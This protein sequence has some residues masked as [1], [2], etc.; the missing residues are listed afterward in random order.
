[1]SYGTPKAPPAASYTI[2]GDTAR[3]AGL[4]A[5]DQRDMSRSW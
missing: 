1:M 5:R 3:D 2:T 4:E